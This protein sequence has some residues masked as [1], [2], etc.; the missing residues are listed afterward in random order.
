MG[1]PNVATGLGSDNCHFCQCARRQPF[2]T[3][4]SRCLGLQRELSPQSDLPG[5]KLPSRCRAIWKRAYARIWYG[6][7]DRVCELHSCK[8]PHCPPECALQSAAIF[9]TAVSEERSSH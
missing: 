9:M 8:A 4:G 1:N 7:M 5:S 6:F 3:I 2:T